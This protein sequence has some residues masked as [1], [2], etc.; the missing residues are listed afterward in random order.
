MCRGVA[1]LHFMCCRVTD[2]S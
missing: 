2:L 1:L